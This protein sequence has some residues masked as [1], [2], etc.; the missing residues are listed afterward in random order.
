MH[1]DVADVGDQP[2]DAVARVLDGSQTRIFL[3]KEILEPLL[4][5]AE[6]AMA[7]C[8]RRLFMQAYAVTTSD[9][10]RFTAPSST[11]K[12]SLHP[13]DRKASKKRGHDLRSRRTFRAVGET[14]RRVLP[15][16]ATGWCAVHPMGALLQPL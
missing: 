7:P 2:Q 16:F 11:P 9:M 5:S 1:E 13:K 4:G 10:E 8:V 6:S 12:P 15:A 14:D 3:A